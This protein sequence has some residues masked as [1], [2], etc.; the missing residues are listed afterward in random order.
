MTIAYSRS[1][2]FCL[3]FSNQNLNMITS[4]RYLLI[5]HLAARPCRSHYL[6]DVYAFS[7]PIIGSSFPE[8]GLT[9]SAS[10]L[11]P[12][13]TVRHRALDASILSIPWIKVFDHMHDLD[14]LPIGTLYNVDPSTLNISTSL[15]KRNTAQ[16]SSHLQSSETSHNLVAIVSNLAFPCAPFAMSHHHRT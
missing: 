10:R 1:A 16:G 15:I 4:A 11:L 5:R 7:S 9:P 12:E 8:G 3:F 6:D 14:A 13:F 2:S